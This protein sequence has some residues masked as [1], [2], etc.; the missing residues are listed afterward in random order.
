M[1]RIFSQPKK[2][3]ESHGE[4]KPSKGWQVHIRYKYF[5][6]KAHEEEKLP[7]QLLLLVEVSSLVYQVSSAHWPVGHQRCMEHLWATH[8]PMLLGFSCWKNLDKVPA[9]LRSFFLVEMTVNDKRWSFQLVS[10]AMKKK[11]GE[12]LRVQTKKGHGGVTGSVVGKGSFF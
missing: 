11:L 2:M 4:I 8:S 6:K 5:G 7:S 12:R 10:S 3:W 9:L 1:D